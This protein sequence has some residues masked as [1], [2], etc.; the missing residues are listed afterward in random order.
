[1][2]GTP[3]IEQAIA[4]LLKAHEHLKMR[5]PNHKLAKVH[6]FHAIHALNGRGVP[7]PE[8]IPEVAGPPE[9]PTSGGVY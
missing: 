9:R 1:M 4:H 3:N 7:M 8:S 5:K 6:A 2:K